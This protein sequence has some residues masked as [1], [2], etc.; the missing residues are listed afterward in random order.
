[1]LPSQ[2]E[3]LKRHVIDH[4]VAL[5]YKNKDSEEHGNNNEGMN[6]NLCTIPDQTSEKLLSIVQRGNIKVA[7]MTNDKESIELDEDD[8]M[9]DEMGQVVEK[10]F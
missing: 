9:F 7:D 4:M 8:L 5:V 10:A 1:M 6:K 2:Y 3:D